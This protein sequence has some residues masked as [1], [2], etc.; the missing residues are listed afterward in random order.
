MSIIIE[1]ILVKGMLGVAYYV[2]RLKN[3]AKNIRKTPKSYSGTQVLEERRY[4]MK[5]RK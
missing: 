3:K 5:K 4:A 1:V 2:I